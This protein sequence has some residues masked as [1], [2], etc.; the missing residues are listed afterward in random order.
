MPGIR[1]LI[2]DDDA[3]IRGL[4]RATIAIAGEGLRVVGEAVDGLDGLTKWRDERP[5]VVV[6]DQRMPGQTGLET[7]AQILAE[8]PGQPIGLFTAY[9]DSEVVA[10]AARVGVRACLSKGEVSRLPEVLMATGA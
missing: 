2:V 6:L 5:D 7:A 4:L 8:Q 3:D 9:L 10:E 1:V